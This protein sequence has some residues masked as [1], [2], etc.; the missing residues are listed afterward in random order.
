MSD[1]KAQMAR[2]NER[3]DKAAEFMREFKIE[4]L[5]RIER[6]EQ[7]VTTI[8]Q[9]L[10]DHLRE[11]QAR[12]AASPPPRPR[13]PRVVRT[14][15]GKIRDPL[16]AALSARKADIGL[17]TRQLAGLLGYPRNTVSNWL[18]RVNAPTHPGDRARIHE[19]VSLAENAPARLIREWREETDRG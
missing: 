14:P 7:R 3:M 9:A 8:E 15:G 10:G 19:W 13:A 16:L 12:D 11:H 4:V 1:T 5:E 2:L 6:L 18:N 17:N